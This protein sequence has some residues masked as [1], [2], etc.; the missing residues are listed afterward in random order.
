MQEF[1]PV[2]LGSLLTLRCLRF[3]DYLFS[4]DG[5]ELEIGEAM[6]SYCAASSEVATGFCVLGKPQPQVSSAEL[7]G[8]MVDG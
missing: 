7:D 2:A 4:S 8:C 5:E 6:G 1:S 3:F